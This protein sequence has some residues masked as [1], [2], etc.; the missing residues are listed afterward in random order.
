MLQDYDEQN[1]WQMVF[2][3]DLPESKKS[4]RLVMSFYQIHFSVS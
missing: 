2:A 4:E 1:D 3:V